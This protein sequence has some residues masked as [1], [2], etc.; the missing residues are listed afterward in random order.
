MKKLNVYLANLGVG[1]IKLHNLHWNVSGF[2]FKQVHEYL[3]SMYDDFTD[4][5]D[6]VAEYERMK[7]HYPPASYKEFLALSTIS[8]LESCDV[9]AKKAVQIALEDLKT[10]RCLATEIRNESDA[11]GQFMLVALMEDHIGSY[12]KSIWFMESMVK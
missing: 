6:A 2:A 9:E 12:D 10:M 3:E 8:E 7:G 4:K 11:E 1:Y 5:L